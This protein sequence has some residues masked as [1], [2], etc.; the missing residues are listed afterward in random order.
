MLD[1]RKQISMNNI[2][3]AA[4]EI[5]RLFIEMARDYL[6]S[7]MGIVYVDVVVSCLTCLDVKT[8]NLFGDEKDLHDQDGILVGV[9]F[10][11]KILIRLAS[12]SI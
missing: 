3:Q 7:R 2:S 4:W 10:I 8:T 1:I 9:A 6:P 11:E 5:K 12:L